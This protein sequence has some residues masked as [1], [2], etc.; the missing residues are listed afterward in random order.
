V[1]DVL[2]E[3]KSLRHVIVPTRI[4]KLFLAPAGSTVEN[5]AELLQSSDIPELF[6][7]V[8]NEYDY[9][10]VDSSPVLR[11]TNTV[12]LASQGVGVVVYVARANRTP[13]PMVQYSLGLLKDARVIGMILNS[14]EMHRIS[15]L[16]YTYQ[17]PNYAYYSNA[18]AYGY[19]YYDYGERKKGLRRPR[20]GGRWETTRHDIA[21]WLRRTFLPMD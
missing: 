20:R 7:D 17:Y 10:F 5:S 19:D 12:I 4:D 13:K 11:V 3:H 14:I 2:K 21:Q 8:R 6:A 16:Y 18:Y 9:I 15:S 1:T